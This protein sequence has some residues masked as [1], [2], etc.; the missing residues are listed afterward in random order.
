MTSSL[1]AYYMFRCI[2]HDRLYF[3]H[4][5][6]VEFG[7]ISFLS[8]DKSVFESIRR[9]EAQAKSIS[10]KEEGSWYGQQAGRKCAKIRQIEIKKGFLSQ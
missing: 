3:V 8:Y 9:Y 2:L 1:D 7:K 10:Y 5:L 4:K 6:L